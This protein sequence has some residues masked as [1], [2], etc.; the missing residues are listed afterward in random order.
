LA[1]G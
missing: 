1:F